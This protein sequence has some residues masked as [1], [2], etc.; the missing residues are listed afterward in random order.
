MYSVTLEDFSL[1]DHLIL[2]VGKTIQR[3]SV[4]CEIE[5]FENLEIKNISKIY[6]IP[7][8]IS[9]V[10]FAGSG[11][12]LDSN[13]SLFYEINRMIRETIEGN[14]RFL[15]WARDAIRNCED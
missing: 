15:D 2:T 12:F 9:G 3:F 11:K 6:L 7:T 10:T 8:D 13:D 14:P 4:E 5:V 1:K